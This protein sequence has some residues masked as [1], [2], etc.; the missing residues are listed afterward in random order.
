MTVNEM[1]VNE[2]TGDEMTVNEM[3]VNEMNVNEITVDETTVDEKT[4]DEMTC[5]FPDNPTNLG[6]GTGSGKRP[7]LAPPA[8]AVDERRRRV[9][10]FERR[11]VRKAAVESEARNRE[12]THEGNQ[13]SKLEHFFRTVYSSLFDLFPQNS[14]S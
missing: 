6:L 5:Y 10:K 4:V 7:R 13:R 8:V 12:Q 1:T 14:S 11:Q 9:D 3:T 2:M